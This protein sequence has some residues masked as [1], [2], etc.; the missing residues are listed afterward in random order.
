MNDAITLDCKTSTGGKVITAS[1]G[2]V[3]NQ[4]AVAC[5]GDQ[6]TCNCGAKNCRG[7]GVIVASSNRPVKLNGKELAKAGDLVDTGCGKCFLQSSP[8]G[9]S[10]GNGAHFAS[11]GSGISL[12]DGVNFGSA[13][14]SVSFGSGVNVGAG[15][16]L[17]ELVENTLTNEQPKERKQYIA[18][19]G[20]QYETGAN[21]MMFVA[22]AIRYIKKTTYS[23]D[24]DYS[25]VLV[26][27]GYTQE[28]IELVQESCTKYNINLIK[29]SSLS[30]ITSYLNGMQQGTV[31]KLMI[32]SHGLPFTIELGYKLGPNQKHIDALAINLETYKNIMPGIFSPTAKIESYACRT[33]MGNPS[34]I[35]VSE[36]LDRVSGTAIILG[37]MGQTTALTLQALKTQYGV[38]SYGIEDAI[39]LDPQPE[40]SLAQQMANYYQVSVKAFITRTDY[41]ATWGTRLDRI[42][43]DSAHSKLSIIDSEFAQ[44]FSEQSEEREKF[45]GFIYAPYNIS[46]ALHDVESSVISTPLIVGPRKMEFKPQ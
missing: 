21:K 44:Q 37:A 20:G 4:K 35:K 26:A 17:S 7:V 11:F 25:L 2:M 41:S 5:V 30:T 29:V 33:G 45:K 38:G 39:Q 18:I 42:T 32:F 19:A 1:S 27:T 40:N 14:N 23:K 24:N 31:E 8:H 16:P 10:L 22:Q 15:V 13:G 28:Q 9:V 3:I 36:V 6:A 34:D 12:G 46:G 43:A